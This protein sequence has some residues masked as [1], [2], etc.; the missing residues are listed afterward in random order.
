MLIITVCQSAMEQVHRDPSIVAEKHDISMF[1]A[2]H[3]VILTQLKTSMSRITGFEEVFCNV[4]NTCV[5]WYEQKLY[6]V[7]EEKYT[8]VKVKLDEH[9]SLCAYVIENFLD[10]KYL[11]CVLNCSER[12]NY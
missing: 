11:L 4:V 8:I 3:N 6:L 2:T 9:A 5:S 10:I 1:L 12:E 7:P